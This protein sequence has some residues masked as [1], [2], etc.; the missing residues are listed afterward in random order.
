MRTHW[1]LGFTLAIA[2]FVRPVAAQ[3]PTITSLQAAPPD[4]SPAS[5]TGITGG[6]PNQNF[7]LYV[8]FAGNL[9]PAA[10]TNITWTDSSTNTTTPLSVLPG[11]PP[12]ANQVLVVVPGNLYQNVVANP[13]AISIVAHEVSRTSNAVAFAINPALKAAGPVLPTATFQTAYSTTVCSG[14]TAPY[15]L[16]VNGNPPP[17]L[18]PSGAALSGTPTQA[19]LFTFSST[20]LD[21]WGN[22]T[23]ATDTLEVVPTPTLTSVTPN[24]IASGSAATLSLVG[25][26]FVAPVGGANPIA[27]SQVRWGLPALSLGLNTTFVDSTHLTAT[28]PASL[29]GSP[30]TVAI[31]VLQPGNAVSNSLPVTIT[32]GPVITNS[33]L[34]TGYTG[35]PYTVALVG[36]GGTQPY[37]WS[38][39]G[40]PTGLTLAASTGVISGTPQNIGSFNVTITLRD[41]TLA[42][43]SAQFTLAVQAPITVSPASALPDGIVGQSYQASVSA[44]G[45]TSSYVFSVTAGTLPPG[46]ALRSTGAIAGTPTTAGKYSFTVTATDSGGGTGSATLSLNVRA[47]ALTV[48]GTVPSS[49]PAGTPVSIAFSGAGGAAP[50]RL[51]SSGTLPPGTAFD[52]S[53]LSGTPTTPGTYTFHI[54]VTDATG[55]SAT[56]DYT[57]TVTS[58]IA[59]TATLPDGQTG[60]AYTGSVTAKGGTAPHTFTATGLPAGLSL[61]SSGPV[62]GTPTATGRFSVIVTATDAKGIL[63]TA[64]FPVS[65]TVPPL[66][67]T[68]STLPSGVVGSGYSVSLAAVGGATPYSWTVS[69]L[70]AG[71][72]ASP[73]GAIT[74]TPTVAGTSSLSVT[75]TDAAGAKATA[76]LSLTIVATRVSVGTA[77]L[78]P[79][80]VGVAYQASL[81]ATGGVAP[82]AWTVTG[83]PAGLSSSSGSISGTPTVAGAF[84]ITATVIDGSRT[85]ASATLTLTIAQTALTISTSTLPSAT[86]GTPYSTAIRADGGTPP[87]SFSA[88]GLPAGLA[89]S[90]GGTLSGVPTVQGSFTV[91]VS[92]TDSAGASAARS[93]TLAVAMPAV[94][95][96]SINGLSD[97]A[98]PLQQPRVQIALSSA[99][100]VD[101]VATLTLTFTPDSG[102]DDPGIQFSSGGRT[103]RITIPAG[104]TSGATDVGVQTGSVA[105][106]IAIAAQLTASG[107]DVTPSPAP[108]RTIRIAAAAPSI[109]SISATRVASGFNVVISGVVTDREVTQAL[110]TFT[111]AAGSN[112]QTTSLTVPV[113]S[114]FS[115]YFT[116]SAATPYG[117][118]FSY[119]QPFTVTGNVQAVGSVT[120]T[121]V[122]R[123]GSSA[124]ASATLN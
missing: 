35:T 72:S 99:F 123:I 24:S 57:V 55:A 104:A 53:L 74:G 81:A 12:T 41:S 34:P 21:F 62:T 43:S 113:D 110:F 33:S 6:S 50:Y 56:V 20:C 105:G 23:S 101:I 7:T 73:A 119:T 116:S 103:A 93:Y 28:V 115:A 92:V 91:A 3:P 64:T 2:A 65:I 117:G 29:T 78:P 67:V 98:N 77:T 25:T 76:S 87:V 88:T 38:A 58:I 60:I 124:S 85:Q 54:T 114:L 61:A 70:P 16:L 69:G 71:L 32:G 120:V 95:P 63:G 66:T 52:G 48:T 1:V 102:A 4:G 122:N 111:P 80:V 9:N 45:G 39:T 31:S 108:R 94:P 19:G 96:L 37:T 30:G 18:T 27:G 84:T 97:T 44:T 22:E 79:G 118:Q 51:T 26:G 75:A 8:N 107:Q 89:L 68:T 112:L 42:S 47:S 83:L 106:T 14:G 46:L 11:N 90:A 82:F 10:F 13:I 59:V 40:L 49:V 15:S 121:L 5:V 86:L 109:V 36:N 100:P 17:G